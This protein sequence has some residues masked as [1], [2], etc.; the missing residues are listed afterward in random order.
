MFRFIPVKMGAVAVVVLE[1]I[2]GVLLPEL[3][4]WVKATTGG[5][6]AVIVAEAV[7][8]E[9]RGHQDPTWAPEI[10]VVRA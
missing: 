9:V 10:T 7:E 4:L 3:E 2:L 5:V 8:V 6:I 1:I